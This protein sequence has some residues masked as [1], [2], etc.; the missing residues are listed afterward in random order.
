MKL[1]AWVRL[2]L[3]SWVLAS[4]S[5]GASAQDILVGQIGPFTGMPTRDPYD[6][7]DG[8]L[9]YFEQVNRSGGVHGHK[10]SL[11]TLD[12]AFDAST[13]MVRFNEAMARQPVALITPIG[14]AVA[15]LLKSGALDTANIVVLNA[16]PGAETFR[17]PGHSKLFH[18]RSSDKAQLAKVLQHCKSLGILRI[19][20][21]SEDV[22]AAQ[23]RLAALR[24]SAETLGGLTITATELHNDPKALAAAAQAAAAEQPQAVIVLGIP[25]FMAKAIAQL[26]QAGVQQATY[27]L[28]YLDASLVAKVAGVD[29]ARGVGI[30]QALPNPNGQ[31]LPIQREFQTAMAKQFPELKTYSPFNMEGYV[32][33]RVL[34]TALR[35]M[36]GTPTPAALAKS[37]RDMGWTDL[38]GFRVDFSQTNEGSTW[39]DIAVM[40]SNG[41]L[42]F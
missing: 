6:I 22:T 40:S 23:V 12:D 19:H 3:A 4:A 28:S 39:S 10:I 21:L 31:K 42:I 26:R 15:G 1:I 5:P 25:I 41:K 38:G 35:R 16:V 13:F 34:V 2:A 27:A 29:G 7:R 33:A 18:V 8:A 11:F 37:L 32:T 24:S 9:A 36:D 30:T 14:T 20:V 17:H